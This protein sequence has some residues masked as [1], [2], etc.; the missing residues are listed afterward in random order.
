MKLFLNHMDILNTA[1]Y[2]NNPK[3]GNSHHVSGFIGC[4][5]RVGPLGVVQALG[6]V[7]DVHMVK[8]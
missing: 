5:M 2:L 6:G 1:K 7:E 3:K 8:E 4:V